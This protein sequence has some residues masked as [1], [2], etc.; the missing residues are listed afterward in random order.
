MV[1]ATGGKEGRCCLPRTHTVEAFAGWDLVSAAMLNRNRVSPECSAR[2]FGGRFSISQL[3][4]P[5]TPWR[6]GEGTQHN[7]FPRKAGETE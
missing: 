2:P 4:I 5:E 7:P 3:F 6:Q 1:T